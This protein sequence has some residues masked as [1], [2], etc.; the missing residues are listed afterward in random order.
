MMNKMKH[1]Y[2]Q[3]E[4]SNMGKINDE[5]KNSNVYPTLDNTEAETNNQAD[6]EEGSSDDDHFDENWDEIMRD[7]QLDRPQ[8]QLGYDIIW[9]QANNGDSNET[10][11]LRR[12][13]FKY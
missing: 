13:D 8:N 11:Q 1:D 5:R 6:Q 4:D 12:N 9:T 2:L 10:D 7:E 3:P